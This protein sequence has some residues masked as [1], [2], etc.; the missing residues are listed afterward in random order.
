MAIAT[1]ELAFTTPIA[2]YGLYLNATSTIYPWI[3]F[4]DT[5]F[6]YSHVDQYPT[7]IWKMSSSAIIS[8]EFSRWS[9]VFCALLFFAFF[10]FADEARRN[11]NKFF[12]PVINLVRR[13]TPTRPSHQMF[14]YVYLS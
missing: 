7:V 13:V 5:H 4:A 14:G 10:G 2:A 6:N 8:F 9:V 3:S 1:A 11:Y 12:A